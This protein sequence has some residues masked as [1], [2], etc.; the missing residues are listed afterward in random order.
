[1]MNCCHVVILCKIYKALQGLPIY[2]DIIGIV[3]EYTLVVSLKTWINFNYMFT[4]LTLRITFSLVC[5]FCKRI[6][7]LHQTLMLLYVHPTLKLQAGQAG[8][9]KNGEKRIIQYR[10][11]ATVGWMCIVAYHA[12]YINQ[13]A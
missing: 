12:G 11:L 13:L 5:L 8:N 9:P 3:P 1:M 2:L 7:Y 4:S 10:F 6:L